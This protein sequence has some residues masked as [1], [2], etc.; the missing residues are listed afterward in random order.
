MAP[1]T[2]RQ[3]HTNEQRSRGDLTVKQRGS[4]VEMAPE[5]AGSSTSRIDVATDNSE[6][7]RQA[8]RDNGSSSQRANQQS[9][10]N[11]VHL[12]RGEA[13]Q[14]LRAQA[15]IVKALRRKVLSLRVRATAA[16]STRSR[17][18]SEEQAALLP[19]A[20]RESLCKAITKLRNHAFELPDQHKLFENLA[21]SIASDAFPLDSIAFDVT[22]SQTRAYSRKSGNLSGMR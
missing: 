9:R 2:K 19:P 15:V 5:K 14:R 20:F 22:S 17:T 1:R 11:F 13:Q 8:L 4:D 3:K 10:V 18:L 6:K 16:L 12:E 21:G 7:L